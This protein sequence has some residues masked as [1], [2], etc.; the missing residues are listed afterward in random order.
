MRI[1]NFTLIELLVVVAIIAILAA[2]LLPAMSGARAQTKSLV[3]K[4]NLKSLGLA[5]QL[6]A[7]DWNG[8]IVPHPVVVAATP[9]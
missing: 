4:N 1:H 7:N 8:H 3:Y 5:N 6:Y 9:L 2:L